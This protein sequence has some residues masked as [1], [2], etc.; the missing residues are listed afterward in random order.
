MSDMMLHKD[1]DRKGSVFSN[2]ICK[3]EFQSAWYQDELIGGKPP[4]VKYDWLYVVH[5]S[6]SVN[7]TSSTTCLFKRSSVR[8]S[9]A[10]F[11]AVNLFA[12]THSMLQVLHK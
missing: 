5:N 9:Q 10:M 8:Q 11:V 7:C 6:A 3:R 1:Y 2:K 4:V 12:A